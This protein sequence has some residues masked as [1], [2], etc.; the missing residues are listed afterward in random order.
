MGRGGKWGTKMRGDRI[1]REKRQ[2]RFFN[3]AGK[4]TA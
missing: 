3:R 1:S 4:G 2:I